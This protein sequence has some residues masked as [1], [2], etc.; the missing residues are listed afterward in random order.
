MELINGFYL[1]FKVGHEFSHEK[2]NFMATGL[3]VECQDQALANQ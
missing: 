1:H 2:V 3:G